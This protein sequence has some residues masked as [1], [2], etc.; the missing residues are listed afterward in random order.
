MKRSSSKKALRVLLG[1][2]IA[3]LPAP[4][5]P[6][7]GEPVEHLLARRSRS[8]SA[9]PRGSSASASSSGT[10][11][12]RK[13]GTSFSS[14]LFSRAGTP[15]LRKYFWAS[16]SA[17]T[18]LQAAGT[19]M[20]SSLKTI[21][22]S[23][24]RISLVVVLEGDGRVRA[25]GPPW[26][27]AARSASSQLRCPAPRR[28]GRPSVCPARQ[29]LASVST[30]PRGRTCRSVQPPRRFPSAIN[31]DR[32]SSRPRQNARSAVSRV[33][34]GELPPTPPRGHIGVT[35]IDANVS[36]AGWSTR[37]PTPSLFLTP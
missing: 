24:L 5:G 1:G 16:T 12:H 17:A 20:P 2:E 35:G 34:G 15:A 6:A 32:R 18:W 11:R 31:R 21:E 10:E 14:T 22:P 25:I 13:E 29:S 37:L 8:R 26:C 28:R 19:S 7:A 36:L 27:S 9:R 4:V 33:G 23:G 3:A 30:V